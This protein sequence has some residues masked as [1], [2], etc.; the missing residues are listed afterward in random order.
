MNKIRITVWSDYVCPFCYLEAPVL[1][2]LREEYGELLEVDW[3]AF[4]L[5]PEPVPTLDP[6]GDYLQRVWN[7]AVYPMAEERGLKIKL[8][9]VQPRSRRAMELA[10]L[11]R[12]KGK[13]DAVHEA[14]FR[15]FFQDGKDLDGLDVLVDIGVAAGLES[16]EVL[17]ALQAGRYRS[18]VLEDERQAAQLGLHGVPAL[19]VR[20]ED[21][22][23]GKWETLSGAQPYEA[24]RAAVERA[25]TRT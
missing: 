9:P 3:R 16:A 18:Q 7:A 25:I 23:L 2:R 14:L 12:Q 13:F 11:A 17:Q 6:E 21:E 5:R 19:L 8:P 24:V 1:N 20:R 4:E 10:E 22:P 15:A